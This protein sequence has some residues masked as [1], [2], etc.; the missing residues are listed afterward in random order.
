MNQEI[1]Y[2]AFTSKE[3]LKLLGRDDLK[4]GGKYLIK[5][6]FYGYEIVNEEEDISKRL[7]GN[8]EVVIAHIGYSEDDIRHSKFTDNRISEK[9][10]FKL[11][12]PD[13]KI[14]SRSWELGSFLSYAYKLTKETGNETTYSKATE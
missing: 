1:G 3:G 7:K 11:Q 12:L 14:E 9:V 8:F 6:I 4:V 13:G 10:Y 2:H 5:D